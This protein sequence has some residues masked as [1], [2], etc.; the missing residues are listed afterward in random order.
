[1]SEHISPADNHLGV[2]SALIW[3]IFHSVL[4]NRPNVS[5][6]TF[7]DGWVSLG[8]QA[9]QDISPLLHEREIEYWPD[10]YE[11][12]D[13]MATAVPYNV[14]KAAGMH[15]TLYGE[16]DVDWVSFYAQ[17][18]VTY[19]IVTHNNNGADTYLEVH[20]ASGQV[21][22]AN[23]NSGNCTACTDPKDLASAV[24]FTPLVADTYFVKISSSPNGISRYGSFDLLVQ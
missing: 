20:A 7:W 23:D 24:S 22:A 18:G 13:V 8:Y 12:N 4:P 9:I 15:L 5:F 2:D 10:S 21:L 17:S 19:A 16:G 6:E 3:N 11:P 14:L 1:M